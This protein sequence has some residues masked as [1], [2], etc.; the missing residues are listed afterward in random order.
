MFL[1]VF[2]VATLGKGGHGNIRLLWNYSLFFWWRPLENGVRKLEIALD[3]FISFFGRQLLE[4]G[5][6]E[7]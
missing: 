6:P 5:G 3:V 4:K 1:S 2:F 7:I